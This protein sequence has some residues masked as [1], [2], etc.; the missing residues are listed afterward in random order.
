MHLPPASDDAHRGQRQSA[1]YGT[2][3]MKKRDVPPGAERDAIAG[4]VRLLMEQRG[5]QEKEQLAL[6][7]ELLHY[8]PRHARRKLA[9]DTAWTGVEAAAFA[10]HFGVKLGQVL[11]PLVDADDPPPSPPALLPAVLALGNAHVPCEVLLS[12]TT[13]APPFT[14]AFVAI[15]G[16]GNLVVVPAAAITLPAREVDVLMVRRLPAA[17]IVQSAGETGPHST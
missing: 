4:C 9:G 13:A 1:R 2:N 5:L 3:H 8:T 15:G 6:V 10:Q 14:A 12:S 11:R 16:P 17:E 7:A